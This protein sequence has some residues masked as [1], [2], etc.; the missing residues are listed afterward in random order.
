MNYL[1][2]PK[3]KKTDVKVITESFTDTIKRK[4]LNTIIPIRPLMGIGKTPKAKF[5]CKICGYSWRQK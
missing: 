2:C 3:C 1:V 5:V 4:S